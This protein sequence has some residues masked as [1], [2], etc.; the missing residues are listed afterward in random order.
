MDNFTLEQKPYYKYYN[1]KIF[2]YNLSIS[3]KSTPSQ[4]RLKIRGL[5]AFANGDVV[6]LSI[7]D[8]LN[9]D[10]EDTN[11]FLSEDISINYIKQM[12]LRYNNLDK[13]I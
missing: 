2:K 4:S 1:G 12:K 9:I 13:L 8:I 10:I 7:E 6:E 3:S 5:S 11:A